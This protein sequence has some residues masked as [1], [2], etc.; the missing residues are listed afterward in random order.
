[1]MI[2]HGDQKP[3][4]LPKD[5]FPT[6][7]LTLGQPCLIM[8]TNKGQEI[9]SLATFIK[10]I[11]I[12]AVSYHVSSFIV[13]IIGG[14]KGALGMRTLS[15]FTSVFIF[16]QL[17]PTKEVWEKLIVSEVS[18]RP[19]GVLSLGVLSLGRVW[20]VLSLGGCTPRNQKSGQIHPTGMLSCFWEKFA[21]KRLVPSP[22]G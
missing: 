11:P 13:Y 5:S 6:V 4:F 16:T 9:Q 3:C 20:E 14:S 18:V 21:K 10:L 19:R 8:H 15:Q 1:M 17:P 7:R 2:S 22:L 12:K